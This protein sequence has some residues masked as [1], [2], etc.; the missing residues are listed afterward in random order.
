MAMPRLPVLPGVASRMS[1]PA[2][3][4][5]EGLATTSA[6]HV[7]IIERRYGFWSYD[8][9]TMYTLHSSP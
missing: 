9:R 7:R 3:V 6:P 8:A 1:R 5:G 2:A 4:S